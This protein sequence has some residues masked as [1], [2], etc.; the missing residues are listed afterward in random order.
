MEYIIRLDKSNIQHTIQTNGSYLQK[1]S[2]LIKKLLP[3]L[4]ELRV[5]FDA[6]NTDTYSKI[7]INGQWSILLEN[8]EWARKTIDA[9]KT[10]TILAADFVVQADNYKE[11][12]K[13]IE[14]CNSMGIDRINFQ[15]M[16]NWGT[17]A[18]EVFQSKNVYHRAHPDYA[19]L[20]S[21]FKQANIPMGF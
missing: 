20:V 11:I 6:A 9:E 7:R 1:K 8:V 3:T 12:P 18:D 17:W 14:L 2:D 5:S 16:W 19:E 13:F 10:K 21:I 4:A 15:N